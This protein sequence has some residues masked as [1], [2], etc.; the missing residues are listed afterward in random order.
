MSTAEEGTEKRRHQRYSIASGGFAL[1]KWKGSEVL[2]AIIDISN[3]GLCIS[4][5]DENMDM[6]TL[7]KMTVKLISEKTCYGDFIGNCI[8]NT[9][10]EGGFTTSIVKMKRCG[11]AFRKLDDTHKLQLEKFIDS[12]TKK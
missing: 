5:I 9:K 2:G 4:H 11:V 1:L 3:G 6:P 12:M 7:T 10:E 8:W